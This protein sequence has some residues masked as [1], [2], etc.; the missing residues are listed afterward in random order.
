MPCPGLPQG[1]PRGAGG[2]GALDLGEIVGRSGKMRAC[3]D[4][5]AQAAVSDANVLITGE[6][7]TGKERGNPER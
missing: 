1:T 4:L 7:G 5:P 6:S 3:Y 2:Q